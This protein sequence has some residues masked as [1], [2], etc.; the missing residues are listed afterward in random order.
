MA[1]V[2]EHKK[3]LLQEVK[4]LSPDRVRAL[5]DFAAYLREREE[6]EETGQ[7]LGDEETVRQIKRSREAWSKGK[8]KEFVSLDD[9][10]AKLGV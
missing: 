3:R 1:T 5:A 6:W 4:Q 8:K 10:K 2:K 9:L 7:I